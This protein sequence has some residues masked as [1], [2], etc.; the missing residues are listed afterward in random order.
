MANASTLKGK[1]YIDYLLAFLMGKNSDLPPPEQNQKKRKPV[2][3]FE[4]TAEEATKLAN[5]LGDESMVYYFSVNS[6]L[7]VLVDSLYLNTNGLRLVQSLLEKNAKLQ[8]DFQREHLYEALI[9]F[10][11]FSNQNTEGKILSYEDMLVILHTLETGSLN[12]LVR[13][14]LSDKKKIKDL[15][16][17]VIRSIEISANKELV[18]SLIQF[19]S[20]LCYG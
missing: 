18:S 6:G 7:K 11:Y 9:D 16:L 20:N 4:L 19:F 15:F 17:V 1:E 2:C 3:L 12:E 10:L 14:N 8:E 13:S 5:V